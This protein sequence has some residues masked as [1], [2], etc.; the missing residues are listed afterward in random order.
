[1]ESLGIVIPAYASPGHLHTMLSSIAS[2]TVVPSEVIIVDDRHSKE[3]SDFLRL[4]HQ[5]SSLPTKLI[6]NESNLGVTISTSI[7]IDNC[8]TKFLGFVDSDDYLL[9]H[10][11]SRFLSINQE[12][13]GIDLYSSDFSYFHGSLWSE[14]EDQLLK[15]DRTSLT[16]FMSWDEAQIF[17]NIFTHFKV[18]RREL[19]YGIDFSTFIDGVQDLLLN[20]TLGN[21]IKVFMDNEILYLHRLH[22]TQLTNKVMSWSSANLKLNQARSDYIQ[23]VLGVSRRRIVNREESDLIRDFKALIKSEIRANC[24]GE[25]IDFND[26]VSQTNLIGRN[27]LIADKSINLEILK[28]PSGESI[29]WRHN[30]LSRLKESKS[31]LG[32]YLDSSEERDWNFVTNYSGIFDFVIIDNPLL[33]P[34]LR[35]H[36]PGDVTIV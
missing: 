12:N 14:S 27:K 33:V 2:Q 20:W 22:D 16:T 5:R 34:V 18:V 24:S 21:N 6:V 35:A 32:V 30:V 31:L 23:K 26:K 28:V 10:A 29:M 9:P 25:F 7:G 11:I 13:S 3:S 36:V 4:F 8:S 17:D 19:I 1:M 15:R